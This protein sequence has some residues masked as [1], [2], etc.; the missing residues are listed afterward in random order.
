MTAL[1]SS[2]VWVQRIHVLLEPQQHV[3]QVLIFIDA[4][5]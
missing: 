3:K 1:M 2:V 5:G 4:F